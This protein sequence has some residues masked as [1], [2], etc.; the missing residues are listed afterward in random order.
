MTDRISGRSDIVVVGGGN[1][2]PGVGADY[3]ITA[4]SLRHMRLFLAAY[5]RDWRL[6]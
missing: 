3:E 5:R 1:G 4:E 2:H 6:L